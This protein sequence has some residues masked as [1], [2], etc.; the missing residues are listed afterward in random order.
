ME[1]FENALKSSD[2]STIRRIPKADLHNHCLLGIKLEK[3]REISGIA[4]EPFRYQ[5]NGIRDING[6][7]TEHYAPVLRIQGMFEQLVEASFR[8][9]QE[10]GVVLLEMSVD[11]SFGPLYGIPAGK[12]V[13][14]LRNV[15][16][17]VAPGITFRPCLGFPRSF[18]LRKLL[19]YFEAYAG[20]DYFSSIDLYDDEFA[21]PVGNF[22][23]LYRYAR[24]AGLRCTAHTGEFGTAEMVREAVDTLNLD[25]VQH[26]IA[27]ASSPEVMKWLA[28]RKIPLNICPTSNLVLKRVD[29]YAAH[30]IRILYDH[31]VNV[32]INTDDITLFG[33]G[34]SEEYLHL[35]KAGL[36]SAEEL[37][38][39][40]EN[41][42]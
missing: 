28:D 17:K 6:W 34:V 32:T 7:I 13:E 30:P 3:I 26:G 22:R 39:I 38:K 29:S 16:Q 31:G 8:Q 25:A 37:D 40:R 35:Y 15:H 36:F 41:Q 11:V 42:Y 21:Q 1:T 20:F 10:D 14:T 27:A 12:I 18:S 19:R 5:G 2:L 4:V 9:A 33:Q 24:Q 23:E